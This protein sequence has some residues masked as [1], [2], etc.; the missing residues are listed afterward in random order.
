MVVHRSTGAEAV[1]P[2]TISADSIHKWDLVHPMSD[3]LAGLKS[4]GVELK[5]ASLFG[6]AVGP[7][8]PRYANTR[9]LYLQSVCNDIVK[10]L[11]SG[12]LKHMKF[13]EGVE[14][15]KVEASAAALSVNDTA[16]DEEAKMSRKRRA[17]AQP[18]RVSK[19]VRV[20][21]PAAEPPK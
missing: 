6:A 21:I 15:Q 3:S 20:S 18:K 17:L 11:S 2:E 8:S 13:S 19:Q 9:G 16:R 5:F 1:L 14:A 10:Q 4:G 12:Q 7:K